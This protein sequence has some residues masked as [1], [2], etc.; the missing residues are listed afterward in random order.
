MFYKRS[1]DYK[2][3]KTLLKDLNGKN[4]KAIVNQHGNG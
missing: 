1:V 2:T 4:D 3:E